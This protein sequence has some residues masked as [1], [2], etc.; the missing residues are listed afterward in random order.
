M[1]KIDAVDDEFLD[2]NDTHE[3]NYNFRHEKEGEGYGITTYSRKIEDTMRENPKADKRKQQRDDKK[4]RQ[5]EEKDRLIREAETIKNIQKDKIL[6]KI[7]K[8]K[9]ISGLMGHKDKGARRKGSSDSEENM[10]NLMHEEWDENNFDQNMEKIFDENYYE[11]EENDI[12]GMKIYL[13]RL[14]KD[15]DANFIDNDED[16]MDQEQNV[17]KTAVDKVLDSKANLPIQM[18]ADLSNVELE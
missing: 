17:K 1:K 15:I 9:E 18:K 2:K 4:D 16:Q 6:E 13:D 14:E 11:N 10:E 7:R 8:I 3:E 5:K 12:E